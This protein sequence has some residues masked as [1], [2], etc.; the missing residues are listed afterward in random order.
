MVLGSGG[1]AND[2]TD[3][4]YQL[5]FSGKIKQVSIFTIPSGTMGTMA[6]EVSMRYGF[7]GLSHVITTG[8]TSSTDAIAY[9]RRQIQLGVQP[10]MM[11]GGVE[12]RCRGAF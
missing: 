11:V 7:R 1:G 4:Q 12:R 9:A 8:C 6:S 10:M 2:S 5:Y 3:L